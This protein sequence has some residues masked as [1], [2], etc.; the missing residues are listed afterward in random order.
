MKIQLITR[1]MCNYCDN[2]KVLLQQNGYLFTEKLIG[3]DIAREEVLHSYPSQ[4][5]L[6]IVVID[7]QLIGGYSE[8][9]KWVENAA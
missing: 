7:D 5:Q 4:K 3:H 6:P 2:A 9:Y 8:L 1:D